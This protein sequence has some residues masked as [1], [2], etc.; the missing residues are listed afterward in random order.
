DTVTVDVLEGRQPHLSLVIGGV[1]DDVLG[2]AAYM[3]IGALHRLMEEDATV[4]SAAV[5]VDARSERALTAALKAMPA[6]AAVAGQRV[7]VENFRKTMAENMGLTLTFNVGF[8][9]VIA[10]GVVYNAARV[11]LSE[12]S[13]ELASLRVLGFTRAE[14]SIILLGELAILTVLAL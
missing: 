3:E 6:V 7:V 11:S 10:F 13:R 8:A 14:I 12:R 1:V 4:S 5:L 2:I 9:C